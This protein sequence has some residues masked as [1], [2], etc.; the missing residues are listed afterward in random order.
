MLSGIQG[1]ARRQLDADE[2]FRIVDACAREY[3]KLRFELF[4]ENTMKTRRIRSC[5]R[6][7]E[8]V[9]A[10]TLSTITALSVENERNSVEVRL[11]GDPSCYL[12]HEVHVIRETDEGG[13][14]DMNRFFDSIVILSKCD[15]AFGVF[16]NDYMEIT[17]ELRFIPMGHWSPTSLTENDAHREY[18]FTLQHMRPDIGRRI[19]QMYP[20]NYFSRTI[21]A[22]VE[23]TLK[24]FVDNNDWD[25]TEID[26]ITKIRFR[27]ILNQVRFK[28]IQE[29]IRRQLWGEEGVET[30][31]SHLY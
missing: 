4:D 15:Y 16:V 31:D 25:S 27:D 8:A 1:F 13:I 20:L 9:A 2:V 23:T 14:A 12:P 26:G 6:A 10:G 29:N 24:R 5:D 21:L 17:E 30:R 18:L 7:Q 3:G 28:A 22:N 19:P 11:R